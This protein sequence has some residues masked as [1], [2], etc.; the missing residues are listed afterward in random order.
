ME[1]SHLGYENRSPR[2]RLKVQILEAEDFS[3]SLKCLA[4]EHE[5]LGLVPAP[6]IKIRAWWEGGQEALW[7]G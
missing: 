6:L 1:L 2:L 7:V 4:C 5:D 3:Q